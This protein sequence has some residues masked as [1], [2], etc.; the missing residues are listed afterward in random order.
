MTAATLIR[1]SAA[2]VLRAS[3]DTNTVHAIYLDPPFGN[4]QVWTA[5]AGSFDDRWAW[6][7]ASAAGWAALRRH[8]A[9]G[10]DLLAAAVTVAPK[11]ARAYLG[12]IAGILIEGWR[13]LRPTGTLWLHHD[14]TMG[15]YL[16]L[17]GDVVFGPGLQVGTVIWKRSAAKTNTSRSFGRNHDTMAVWAR[18]RAARWRL[19]RCG[20][21]L[22]QGDPCGR[23][24]VAGFAE[25]RLSSTARERVGYPTQKPVA[26]LERV[27]RAATLPGETILDPTCGSGTTL[28]AAVGLGRRAIG[29][30]ASP[31]AIAAARARLKLPEPASAAQQGELF[32]WAAA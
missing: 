16:R 1:G 23:L 13:T 25:E 10:A 14:D 19:W 24:H 29:I 17:L 22:V 6:S 26:L 28:V 11:V 7:P 30:D 5:A 32:G 2:D 15:A 3:I 21:D 4:E 12:V 18:T 27:V 20:S 31:D 8:T 9:V